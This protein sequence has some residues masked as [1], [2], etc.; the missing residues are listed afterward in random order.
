MFV[1][2]PNI[3]SPTFLKNLL[4]DISLRNKWGQ[5]FLVDR[6]IVEKIIEE[7][8]IREGEAVL[9]IGAGIGTLTLPLAQRGAQVYAIEKDKRIFRILSEFLKDYPRVR[10]L[11]GDILDMDLYPILRR[12]KEWKIISNP[13]Y[14]IVGHLLF[15]LLQYP[16]RYKFFLLTLQKEVAEKLIAKAG[17]KEYSLLTVKVRLYGEARIIRKIPKQVFF[18]PPKVDSAL[19]RID[20]KRR[21]K[22]PYEDSIIRTVEKIFQKRR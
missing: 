6:N 9:E 11:E 14:S 8:D 21:R 19:V 16:S 18:P 13:P 10:L 20:I 2:Y 12:E 15:R 5:R 1:E 4:Q 3:Y 17:S 22:I 7:A